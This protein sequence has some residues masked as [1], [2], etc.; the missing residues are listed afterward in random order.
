MD[1]DEDPLQLDI[2]IHPD[3]ETELKEF[4]FEEHANKIADGLYLGDYESSMCYHQLKKNGITHVVVVGDII[5]PAF[6]EVV[7]PNDFFDPKAFSVHTYRTARY[8]GFGSHFT[9]RYAQRL[10]PLI[11]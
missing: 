9:F 10:D 5:R 7:F 1:D 6:P 2:I 11:N 8:A 4:N 3:I